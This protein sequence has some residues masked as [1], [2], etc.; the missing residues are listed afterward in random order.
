MRTFRTT[1]IA[2]PQRQSETVDRILETWWDGASVLVE[3]LD[4]SNNLQTNLVYWNRAPRSLRGGPAVLELGLAAVRGSTSAGNAVE[5]L[6]RLTVEDDIPAIGA[7]SGSLDCTALDGTASVLLN[8]LFDDQVD[9]SS[10]ILDASRMSSSLQ[11]MVDGF[12]TDVQIEP[13]I[14]G[15][16]VSGTAKGRTAFEVKLNSDGTLT[17]ARRLTLKV[18]GEDVLKGDFGRNAAW[19][20]SANRS[21]TLLFGEDDDAEAS[22][23]ALHPKRKLKLVDPED[24]NWS[25]CSGTGGKGVGF[26]KK[27]WSV[28]LLADKPIEE[29]V[30]R[31][32]KIQSTAEFF[33]NETSLVFIDGLKI[34][35]V[36]VVKNSGDL[37]YSVGESFN[38]ERALVYSMGRSWLMKNH[39]LGSN[40]ADPETGETAKVGCYFCAKKEEG[41]SAWRVFCLGEG[42]AYVQDEDGSLQSNAGSKIWFDL[43][44]YIGLPI[45][46]DVGTIWDASEW[47]EIA[48][49]DPESV[50]NR[51]TLNN[52][53]NNPEVHNSSE[54]HGTTEIYWH[55][56]DKR[57]LVDLRFT[58]E[59][60][61]IVPQGRFRLFTLANTSRFGVVDRIV[62]I[63]PRFLMVFIDGRYSP[64]NSGEWRYIKGTFFV[65]CEAEQS[66]EVYIGNPLSYLLPDS[67]YA[68]PE[69]IGELA[70]NN[71]RVNIV[72]RHHLEAVFKH[73]F[74]LGT[75]F[76]RRSVVNW[77]RTFRWGFSG[78]ERERWVQSLAVVQRQSET[79]DDILYWKQM[80]PN[81][82][83]DESDPLKWSNKSSLLVF[84]ANGDLIDPIRID[85]HRKTFLP[86]TASLMNIVEYAQPY[87]ESAQG[88]VEPGTYAY[89]GYMYF[90]GWEYDQTEGKTLHT[91]LHVLDDGRTEGRYRDL[92]ESN[93]TTVY[94]DG[95]PY[96][97][98]QWYRKLFVDLHLEES[99][100][101]NEWSETSPDEYRLLKSGKDCLQFE[102]DNAYRLTEGEN[103]RMSD[104]LLNRIQEGD[105][106]D[107]RLWAFQIEAEREAVRFVVVGDSNTPMRVEVPAA[108]G[109]MVFVDGKKISA[110]LYSVI[111]SAD[112]KT[113]ISLDANV[114]GDSMEHAVVVYWPSAGYGTPVHSGS[115]CNAL[116]ANA[117]H[118]LWEKI[119]QS[120]S[121]D[122]YDK[123]AS[124]E[125]LEALLSE[126][127]MLQAFQYWIGEYRYGTDGT[128][129][130][131][132][133]N[134]NGI[135]LASALGLNFSG[136]TSITARQAAQFIAERKPEVLPAFLASLH[137]SFDAPR[138]ISLYAEWTKH[139]GFEA[140][141][142]EQ[143]REYIESRYLLFVDGAHVPVS[144]DSSGRIVLEIQGRH[145]FAEDYVPTSFELYCIDSEG[146]PSL[147]SST[148]RSLAEDQGF[149]FSNLRT[150]KL[151]ESNTLAKL[152]R[153]FDWSIQ[154]FIR[155]D[156]FKTHID[157]FMNRLGFIRTS[158]EI[159]NSGAELVSETIDEV[160]A[161]GQM[162]ASAWAGLDFDI[163]AKASR[164]SVMLFDSEGGL[165]D[166]ADVDYAD[167]MLKPK[168]LGK[169]VEILNPKDDGVQMARVYWPIYAV[170]Q[171]GHSAPFEYDSGIER[172]YANLRD[173]NFDTIYVEGAAYDV[174]QHFRKDAGN[175]HLEETVWAKNLCPD[176]WTNSRANA[177]IAPSRY[178]SLLDEDEGWWSN[179]ENVPIDGERL[180][181]SDFVCTDVVNAGGSVAAVSIDAESAVVREVV[182]ILSSDSGGADTHFVVFVPKLK[183]ALVFI[184]G[185]KQRE[186]SY[187]KQAWKNG[188]K[189]Y[190]S[191]SVDYSNVP[192]NADAYSIEFQ[193]S[194]LKDGNEHVVVVYYPS[195]SWAERTASGNLRNAVR[196]SLYPTLVYRNEDYVYEYKPYW[197]QLQFK[198]FNEYVQ[199]RL[200]LFCNGMLQ[201][202]TGNPDEE[203][204]INGVPLASYSCSSFELYAVDIL[205]ADCRVS[206][207]QST[208]FEQIF[209]IGN[210]Q[211]NWFMEHHGQTRWIRELQKKLAVLYTG[212]VV[213]VR[214]TII[215]PDPKLEHSLAAVRSW[216]YTRNNR[217]TLDNVFCRGS[218][219][220]RPFMNPS[221]YVE[222]ITKLEIAG[223]NEEEWIILEA[224]D[225]IES[226]SWVP[227]YAREIGLDGTPTGREDSVVLDL[228]A[229]D[230]IVDGELVY[231]SM[232]V[233]D[234]W[235]IA[236]YATSRE[237][238]AWFLPCERIDP[239][240]WRYYSGWNRRLVFLGLEP[241]KDVYI[242]E[243]LDRS[244]EGSIAN[245][246]QVFWLE[247]EFNKK[248]TL[249][250][251]REGL[252]VHPDGLEWCDGKY[253][254]PH[255][256]TWTA[257]PEEAKFPAIV[258]EM[259][260][261]NV[262]WRLVMDLCLD[263]LVGY[264]Q[265]IALVADA[266]L[267]SEVAVNPRITFSKP[268]GAIAN[269]D[270][271]YWEEGEFRNWN[272]W[273]RDDDVFDRETCFVFVNG[274]KIPDGQWTWHSDVNMIEIPKKLQHMIARLQ[275]AKR[276]DILEE[277]IHLDEFKLNLIDE[278]VRTVRE[279]QESGGGN[280]FVDADWATWL[281]KDGFPVQGGKDEIPEDAYILVD[282]PDPRE[283]IIWPVDRIRYRHYTAEVKALRGRIDTPDYLGHDL[284]LY[285]LCFVDGRLVQCG[286]DGT[287]FTVPGWRN[288]EV[289]EAYV[290][291]LHDAVWIDRFNAGLPILNLRNLRDLKVC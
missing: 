67:A 124:Q 269:R 17:F 190:D 252:L 79:F 8:D 5:K 270:C 148:S 85:W 165:I 174:D 187:L 39:L 96:D 72:P 93:W 50:Q 191:D 255:S 175:I 153:T 233:P 32:G 139:I 212:E 78:Y 204:F 136:V 144:V 70:F 86:W 30:V 282:H 224:G 115:L 54:I 80:S 135:R 275:L 59:V 285:V 131:N 291:E 156:V 107:G 289:I 283:G 13:S 221:L 231:T 128:F 258:N 66:V 217:D 42:N 6:A 129:S 271:I 230:E 40:I 176:V 25:Q 222:R 127:G 132:G 53:F 118:P 133:T 240:R 75:F 158:K 145:V 227:V 126:S 261:D 141:L 38:G 81:A 171:E 183:G 194:E 185:R 111:S 284:R 150:F 197:S 262:K 21:S 140:P 28:P 218:L 193:Q 164:S 147:R 209:S 58:D 168:S 178:A 137:E 41:T 73:E 169:T 177:Q 74:R 253:V 278:E 243:T 55:Y 248:S 210:R 37:T 9:E 26:P 173:T 203:I 287:A 214:S 205:N 200:I 184:D 152:R 155:S 182:A 69:G 4:S 76:K 162:D 119:L 246:D 105:S 44:E 48:D 64:W 279:Y 211:K 121:L 170:D 286:F 196:S 235:D 65:E 1:S 234:T 108:D 3:S 94:I 103:L 266:S 201:T 61:A 20:A 92:V 290:F 15:R 232:Y 229:A 180:L 36:D 181:L 99:I 202:V 23:N 104:I 16:S 259:I 226:E 161:R 63:D 34:P 207:S 146:Y 130:G 10:C 149:A 163:G 18:K 62:D 101:V 57:R 122:V 33:K 216:T 195:S 35:D 7:A 143:F 98:D 268:W 241:G 60:D 123:P 215:M 88:T 239:S 242:V 49:N 77:F 256:G 120:A 166:P 267:D 95:V 167:R 223:L 56:G 22:G 51:K 110:G 188:R 24:F 288:A 276:E 273:L 250:L 260:P 265:E 84:D 31:N 213:A 281:D 219:P 198:T 228:S 280:V 102:D 91:A 12:W 14:D 112:G 257:Q 245:T 172:R 274:F 277:W 199:S 27:W 220:V 244:M 2:V 263:D 186:E 192:A 97:Y 206:T 89:T 236:M 151:A 142:V 237:N 114:Y 160:I 90:P 87:V 138:L 45:T 113:Y 116:Y 100:F 189:I 83:L 19:L 43:V 82:W 109:A 249:V 272:A 157:I 159:W 264:D 47:Q 11:A 52:L 208:E 71:L 68:A 254:F 225:D 46:R 154:Y 125:R 29:S 247:K 251:D 238:P 179:E 117:A 106:L 134:G